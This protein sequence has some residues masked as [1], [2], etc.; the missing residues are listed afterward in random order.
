[1]ENR[2][3]VNREEKYKYIT[4]REEWFTRLDEIA[5]SVEKEGRVDMQVLSMLL[6][7]INSADFIVKNFQHPIL[8]NT[9]TKKVTNK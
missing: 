1:M 3:V 2:K 8:L 7:Y 5:M 9:K 4:I 6:G